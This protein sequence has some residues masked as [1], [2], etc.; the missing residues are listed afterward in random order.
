M[1]GTNGWYKLK[2][3]RN[4]PFVLFLLITICSNYLWAAEPALEKEDL[5][6]VTAE[7]KVEVEPTAQDKEISKRIQSILNTTGWF[8]GVNVKVENGVVFLNGK[9]KAEKHKEWASDLASKTEGVVAVVNKI[10]IDISSAT[11]LQEEIFNFLHD[12]WQKL[13]RYVPYLILSF[14]VLFLFW[15]GA[16]LIV[17]IMRT[18][19][20]SKGIHPLLSDV[21][22]KGVAILCFLIG[23]YF[24][25]RILGL[26]TIALTLIGGTGI[27]GIILGI[28]FRDITENLLASVLLSVQ[29]PFK[30]NELVEIEGTIGYVQKLTIRATILMTLDG[31]IIQIPNALV[32]KNIICNFSNNPN[33]RE[34]FVIG[35]GYDESISSAQE[36]AFEVLSNHPSILNEPEPLVLVQDLAPETVNLRIYFWFDGN[37]YNW[38]K[39]KSSAIRLVKRAFQENG[40]SMPGRELGLTIKNDIPIKI[41]G[42]KETVASEK[43][44]RKSKEESSSVA[45]HAEGS[46]NSEADDINKQVKQSGAIEGEDDLLQ[47]NSSNKNK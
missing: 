34:C 40:I 39:I 45:T 32:Y 17:N 22:A 3:Y 2:K 35:I 30:N 13:L 18:S 14:T 46:L 6:L 16:K 23:L 43:K 41:P 37:K 26:T 31:H 27:L 42:E 9:T 36:V 38:Q 19:L 10:E 4:L 24:V 28:A 12:Q 20:K 7:E 47:T 5:K 11:E 29:S 8:E 15:V 21:L 44:K 33:R 25:M 1:V